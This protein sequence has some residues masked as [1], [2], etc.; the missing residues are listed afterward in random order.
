MQ[1]SIS[2]SRKGGGFLLG[3][4]LPEDIFTPEDFSEEQ[5][6]IRDMTR[7][8][9]ESEIVPRIEE[10]ESKDWEVTKS[11]LCG[12]G[13][14]GLLGIEVP[15]QYGGEAL[16]KISAMIVM[17]QLGQV[18]SFA[19]TYGGQ[20]GIGTMPIVYFG[21]LVSFVLFTTAIGSLVF[22]PALLTF[23]RGK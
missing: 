13:E 4:S 17:E 15:E 14:L 11:L 2:I 22:L 9:V 6:L 5:Q 7:Q 10:I 1:E 19:V 23:R 16:D 12:C 20:A 21:I 3:E 8:F 18:G